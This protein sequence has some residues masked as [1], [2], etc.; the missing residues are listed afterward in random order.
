MWPVAQGFR[1]S[2]ENHCLEKKAIEY[3]AKKTS[4]KI[5]VQCSHTSVLHAHD[6]IEH[7]TR[8]PGFAVSTH[9]RGP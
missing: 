4:A 6:G 3:I 8:N 2:D 5:V 9:H 1:P 7:I